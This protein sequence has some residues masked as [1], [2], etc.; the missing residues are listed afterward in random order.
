[1]SVRV[2]VIE[3]E[4]DIQRLIEM[5][6]K[7]SGFVVLTATDGEEGLATALAERPEIVLCDVGMPKKD[8]YT[9]IT[10]LRNQLGASTPV[11]LM[12]TARGQQAE[13][14]QGLSSGA[15]DY[16]VK[17]FS[18]RDLV[19]RIYVAALKSGKKLDLPPRR[20]G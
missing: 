10:E 17:P 14:I 9:V 4:A 1:M 2:L 16:I 11:I 8:G 6:L 19:A 20:E 18:P 13:M 5:K 3:D 7:A 15:D 12:L